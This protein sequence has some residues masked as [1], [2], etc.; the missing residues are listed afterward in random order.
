MS[1]DNSAAV[2]LV[3]ADAGKTQARVDQTLASD[4]VQLLSCRSYISTTSQPQAAKPFRYVRCIVGPFAV[5]A[6]SH[7]VCAGRSATQGGEGR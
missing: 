1:V 7:N 4:D 6:L 3:R 2:R 5:H